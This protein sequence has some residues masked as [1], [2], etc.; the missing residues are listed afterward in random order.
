[1]LSSETTQLSNALAL[2]LCCSTA[3]AMPA[4]KAGAEDATYRIAVVIEALTEGSVTAS[5][6]LRVTLPAETSDDP[7]RRI[8]LNLRSMGHDA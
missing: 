5:E 4:Y 2:S 7:I 8:K 3:K 1:M 6:F